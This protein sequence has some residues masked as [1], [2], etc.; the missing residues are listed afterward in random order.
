MDPFDEQSFATVDQTGSHGVLELELPSGGGNGRIEAADIVLCFRG[1]A[2]NTHPIRV[3]P[4]NP[5][6]AD[7]GT[8][9][10]ATSTGTTPTFL[11][12]NTKIASA[13]SYDEFKKHVDAALAQARPA[14]KTQ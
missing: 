9:L 12:G 7:V 13:I 4:Y 14:T 11:I 10:T 2:G 8:A 6:T 5:T 1:R 3:R